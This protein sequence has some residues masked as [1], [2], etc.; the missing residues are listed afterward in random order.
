MSLLLDAL[1]KLERERA[2]HAPPPAPMV[3]PAEGAR[4]RRAWRVGALA[5][6]GVVMAAGYLGWQWYGAPWIAQTAALPPEPPASAAAQAETTAADTP[7]EQDRSVEPGGE[8]APQ[9]TVP[10]SP[11]PSASEAAADAPRGRERAKTVSAAGDRAA[12]ASAPRPPLS[13]DR[14]V[15]SAGGAEADAASDAT[16]PSPARAAAPQASAARAGASRPAAANKREIVIEQRVATAVDEAYQ[17]FTS[18]RL[19][20]SARKY[21]EAL[22]LNPGDVHAI[23][24]LASLAVRRGDAGLAAR[25]YEQTL[26]LDGQNPEALAGLAALRASA[27]PVG[28]ESRLALALER[29][30]RSAGLWAA[31]GSVQ[32]R[33]GRWGEAAQSFAQAAVLEPRSPDHAYN[34][35][36]ALEQAGRLGEAVAS[37]RHALSL[38]ALVP[39]AFDQEAVRA[40]V[41]TLDQLLEP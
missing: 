20:E 2:A 18:G 5:L 28:W 26:A 30:P 8:S 38:A 32:A 10:A 25:L 7:S 9:A 4:S 37:Y 13:R 34:R 1:D 39:A 14:A 15:P 33:L 16:R 23:L 21:R 29:Y 11:G 24:G 31:L 6:A 36:V 12:V 19:E 40:R 27:D 3:T 22:A 17:A 35:A 41:Q